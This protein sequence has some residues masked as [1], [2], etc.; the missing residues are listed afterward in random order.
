MIEVVIDPR[1]YGI[2]DIPE[3]RHHSGLVERFR[4]QTDLRDS[5]VAVRTVT[6]AVVVHQAVTERKVDAFYD[7][8]HT[9]THPKLNNLP[10]AIDGNNGSRYKVSSL[11]EVEHR[12]RDVFWISNSLDKRRLLDGTDHFGGKVFRQ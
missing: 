5:I 7:F 2:A 6:F 12:L 10:P 11:D 8:V 9:F 1:A 3:V 4:G